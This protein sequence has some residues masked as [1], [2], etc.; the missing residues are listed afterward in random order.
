M[1]GRPS[2]Q[3]IVVNT[4]ESQFWQRLATMWMG[5]YWE[6]SS[7][8]CPE[9]WWPNLQGNDWQNNQH[10]WE[11]PSSLGLHEPKVDDRHT[12]VWATPNSVVAGCDAV[13]ADDRE[14]FNEPHEPAVEPHEDEIIPVTPAPCRDDFEDIL[15]EHS[16]QHF[17]ATACDADLQVDW[18]T[19]G[20]GTINLVDMTA[21]TCGPATKLVVSTGH[22]CNVARPVG[23]ATGAFSSDMD[24]CGNASTEIQ[25][26]IFSAKLDAGLPCS[27][28]GFELG[29]QVQLH[30]LRTHEYNQKYGTIHTHGTADGRQGVRLSCGKLLSVKM[31]NLKAAPSFA[32]TTQH[33]GEFSH[34]G[35]ELLRHDLWSS[36]GCNNGVDAPGAQHF[37]FPPNT[38]RPCDWP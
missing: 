10:N 36:G 22:C 15:L 4:N 7:S 12:G 13:E 5:H 31:S 27:L 23:V 26:D 16:M 37:K 1:A 8:I 21:S 25:A 11:N 6:L 32:R 35:T 20:A 3:Y 30:G 18:N 17:A 9:M 24:M 19:N 38:A 29:E 14:D 33:A 2:V 28:A 34:F